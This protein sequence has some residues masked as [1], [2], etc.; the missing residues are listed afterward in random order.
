MLITWD[1]LQQFNLNITGILHVGAHECQ[2]LQ[3]Y[4]NILPRSK[5]LWIEAMPDKVD[6]NKA[7]YTNILIEQAVVCETDDEPITFNVANNDQSS[8]ILEFGTHST[9]YPYIVYTHT[10]QLTTSRLD[11]ILN[12]IQYSHIQFNFL[13]IDIQGAEL[14]ALIGLGALL[15]NFSYLYIEVNTEEVYKNCTTLE[16]LDIY[17]NG[18][19]FTRVLTVI[20]TEG[21]GDAFW[22]K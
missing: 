15:N 18:F 6:S 16:E 3:S 14:K 17:L 13:N 2:E 8:S 22:I 1:K 5:I 7:N 21:W 10:L 11:T 19:G 20:N 9:A 12:K 4:E